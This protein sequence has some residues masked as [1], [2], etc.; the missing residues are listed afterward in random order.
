MDADSLRQWFDALPVDPAEIVKLEFAV[1]M[2]GAIRELGLN[3][4][5]MAELLETAPAWVAKVLR[6][7]VNLSI[8]RMVKLC[9]AVGCQLQISIVKKSEM[10]LGGT[11]PRKAA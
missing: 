3:R 4:K 6:G 9:D 1:A 2:D 10:P 11:R 8:D 5:Q 7:D